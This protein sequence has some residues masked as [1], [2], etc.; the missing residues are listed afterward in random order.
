[1]ILKKIFKRIL[2]KTPIYDFYLSK[3]NF[4]EI[5]ITPHDPWPGDASI[6]EKILQGDLSFS[7]KKRKLKSQKLLWQIN[8]NNKDFWNEEVHTF[9]WLR[10]L[11]A[12]SGPLA[13]KHARKIIIDWLK[14]NNR[15]N[16][17]TWRLDIIARRISS[18]TT[19]I[20]FLLADKDE[21]FSSILKENLFKQI[22]HLNT[23]TTK[24]SLDKLDKVYAKDDSSVKKFKILRGL[25]LSGVCFEES[26]KSY[27]KNLAL[28]KNEILSN[29]NEEGVHLSRLPSTQLSIL[30]D[31]ITI[32]DIIMAAKIDVPEYLS[33]QIKK[34]AHSLRFFRTL[35]GT[36]STFNGS[37]R[38]TKFVIDKI[39]NAAD[40]KARG[41]GPLT[42][43]SSGYI[44]L[45][46]P[47]ACVIIDTLAANNKVFSKTPHALEV[48]V[49]K[50]RLLGS[51][52]SSFSKNTEWKKILKSTAAHSTVSLEDSD[53][54]IGTD[55]KQKTFSK[56]YT[57]DGSELVE[58]T[59]YGYFNRFSSICFRK[60]ELGNNGKNIAGL[61]KIESKKLNKFNIRFHFSPD[62]KISLSLDKKSVVL[63]TKEQGWRFLYEGQAKLS[64]DPSIFIQDDGKISSTFQIVLSGSTKNPQTNILWGFKRIS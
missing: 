1:M 49:G 10:H 28:L 37:K 48:Y 61:D 14:K 4:S 40:G 27:A 24:N 25:I 29:F 55:L 6:G 60:I 50:N 16:D 13:R 53:A 35:D 33:S 54:F 64:L 20:S 58:L 39:L 11:K 26:K 59:H 36:L 15:W 45:L 62:I 9:S 57:K 34:S 8:N 19:N 51:C 22:K 32:R 52:G 46:V 23:F 17:K 3:N 30:G 43:I 5:L 18:W 63:V 12:R 41:K 2:L 21:E 47:E 42:L 44:K 38:E 56:R 7:S 31:L